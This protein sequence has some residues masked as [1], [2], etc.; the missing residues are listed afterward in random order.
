MDSQGVKPPCIVQ[1]PSHIAEVFPFLQSMQLGPQQSADPR[2][3][4]HLLPHQ[5]PHALQQ[6]PVSSL[7]SAGRLAQIPT[8]P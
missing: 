6:R 3:P 7:V 5:Q 8:S 1:A 4:S 2:M